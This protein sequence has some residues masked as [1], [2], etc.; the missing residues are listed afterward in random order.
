MRCL[1]DIMALVVGAY[2]GRMFISAWG[3]YS[4][5]YSINLVLVQ[6]LHLPVEFFVL[7]NPDLQYTKRY[8]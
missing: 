1:F 3:V 5:K 2:L 7:K 8:V 4:R 6:R